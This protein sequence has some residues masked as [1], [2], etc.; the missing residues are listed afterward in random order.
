M[1]VVPSDSVRNGFYVVDGEQRI[2]GTFIGKADAQA[3][4]G[5]LAEASDDD[6][7]KKK[8]KYKKTKGIDAILLGRSR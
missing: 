6:K 8:K 5:R 7:D 2:S 1:R 4:L 3:E